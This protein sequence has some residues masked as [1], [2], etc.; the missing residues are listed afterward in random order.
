VKITTKGMSLFLENLESPLENLE[1]PLENLESLLENLESPLENL[2]SLLKSLESLE[3]PL[4]SPLE[5]L[6]KKKTKN[7]L[8]KNINNIVYKH[9]LHFFTKIR[10]NKIR[11][12]TIVTLTPIQNKSFFFSL[13]FVPLEL[14]AVPIPA[15]AATPATQAPQKDS[16]ISSFSCL[17]FSTIYIN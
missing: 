14:P 4:E 16:F 6:G 17:S 7:Y 12:D 8:C 1:S 10:Y 13:F 5:N 15:N 11:I 9:S 2:E 3:S